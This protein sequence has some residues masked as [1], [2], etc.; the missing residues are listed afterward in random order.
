MWSL[1]NFFIANLAVADV[2]ISLFTIHNFVSLSSCHLATLMPEIMCSICPFV[3]VAHHYAFKKISA[4]NMSTRVFFKKQA[5]SIDISVL[6][7]SAIA[8]HRYKA[9]VLGAFSFSIVFNVYGFQVSFK[10]Y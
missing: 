1:T 4:K 3:Q 5:L 6:T 7:L 2:I 9:V 10:F 8:I